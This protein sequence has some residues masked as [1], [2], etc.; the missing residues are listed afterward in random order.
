MHV[1]RHRTLKANATNTHID[2]HVCNVHCAFKYICCHTH[3]LS[4][5]VKRVV[6]FNYSTIIVSW[7]ILPS[8]YSPCHGS[9]WL[10]SSQSTKHFTTTWTFRLT[11]RKVFV[12]AFPAEFV[13]TWQLLLVCDVIHTDEAVIIIIIIFSIISLSSLQPSHT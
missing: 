2:I 8:V 13:F 9:F 4:S 6:N 10:V 7:Q 1:Y 3:S 5:I 11:L 12:N